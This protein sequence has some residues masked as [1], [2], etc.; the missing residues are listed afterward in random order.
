MAQVARLAALNKKCESEIAASPAEMC[1]ALLQVGVVELLDWSAEVVMDLVQC[2]SR[3]RKHQ[4]LQACS[5]SSGSVSL[6]VLEA[7]V[8]V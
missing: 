2:Q 4:Q 1:S 6:G 3:E 5:S 7:Q 8:H